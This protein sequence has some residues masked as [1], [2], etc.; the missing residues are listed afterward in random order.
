MPSSQRTILAY[1]DSNTH[2]TCPK[3]SL[4]DSRRLDRHERWPGILAAALGASWQ[5]VEEGLPARTTVHPDPVSG[6]HK[7]GLAVLPAVLES[8]RPIDLV[9]LMLGTND[10]KARFALPA[11]EIVSCVEQLLRCVQ[12]SGTGPQAGAPGLMLV[13]PPL[14]KQR[15]CLA[16]IYQGAEPKSAAL[17]GGLA[18]LAQRYRLPFVNAAGLIAASD[19]DG[20][21]FD[22]EAHRILGGAIAQAVR[23]WP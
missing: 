14:V 18:G 19:I 1:G 21:H 3:T 6:V 13:A 5:V 16:E 4:Q 22:A 23:E 17:A 2:G 11:V 10:L 20:V 12:T 7:N 9:I 8:H 15:G